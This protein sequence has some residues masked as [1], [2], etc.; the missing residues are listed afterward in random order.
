MYKKNNAVSKDMF[1]NKY[2]VTAFDS[3][4]DDNNNLML[5]KN[6][7]GWVRGR[8]GGWIIFVVCDVEQVE[9]EKLTS[10]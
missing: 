7:I 5:A 2:K 1:V 10:F 4:D 8:D 3:P 6:E 9:A